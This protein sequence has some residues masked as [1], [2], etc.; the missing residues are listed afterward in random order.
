MPVSGLTTILQMGV[1]R[2]ILTLTALTILSGP[3]RVTAQRAPLDVTASTP[4][5]AEGQ[6]DQRSPL[7]AA[8]LQAAL[9]PVPLGYLYAGDLGRSLLPTGLM[10][11]GATLLLFESVKLIDWT[12]E[13]GSPALLYVGLGA[14]IGGYVYGILDAADAARDRNARFVPR[15]AS[16]LI[17]PSQSGT[18]IGVSLRI[19]TSRSGHV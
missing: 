15:G 9:P 19:P 6:V 4:A 12:D 1:V 8:I 7:V 10:V 11:G 17:V 3:A 13:G 5:Q 18:R 2:R 14:L 16:L